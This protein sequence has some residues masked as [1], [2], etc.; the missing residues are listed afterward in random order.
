MEEIVEEMKEKE[1]NEWK[2]RNRRNKKHSLSTV[3]SCK[4]SM[5]YPTVSQS[6]LDATMT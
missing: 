1:E 5:P 6:Q 4:D 3:I 2:W